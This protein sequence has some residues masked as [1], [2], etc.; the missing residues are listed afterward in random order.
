MIKRKRVCRLHRLKSPNNIEGIPVETVMRNGIE[1]CPKCKKEGKEY[2]IK[3]VLI[4][5]E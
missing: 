1:Y 4:S 2:G 3:T 5:E